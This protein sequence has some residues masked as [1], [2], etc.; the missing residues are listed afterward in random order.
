MLDSRRAKDLWHGTIALL[1]FALIV[2]GG[3][4][5]DFGLDDILEGAAVVALVFGG[6]LVQWGFTQIYRRRTPS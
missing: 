5:F 3:L 6:V 4:V 1:G 2:G